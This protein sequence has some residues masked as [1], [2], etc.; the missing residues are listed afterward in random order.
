MKGNISI[1][2]GALLLLGVAG[3]VLGGCCGCGDSD[4][5]DCCGTCKDPAASGCS[6]CAKM[7]ETGNGWC[8]GCNKGMLGGKKVACK[9]CYSQRTGG[10]VCGACAGK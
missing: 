10:P 2:A 5:A 4:K 1:M 7:K 8:D 9:G 6:G 3:L